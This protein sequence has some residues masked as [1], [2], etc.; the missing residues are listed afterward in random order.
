MSTLFWKAFKAS[1]VLLVAS[2]FVASGASAA[3]SNSHATA[4]DLSTA[5]MNLD[6]EPTA[7][8][9]PRLDDA[10]LTEPIPATDT[11]QSSVTVSPT[12]QLA[13]STF[14]EPVPAAGDTS[15][16]SNQEILQQIQRYGN[17]GST[18]LD[19]VTNVGQLRDVSPGDWAYEA[20]RSLVERY[21]CIAGYPDGTYR[22]NRALTRYEFAAGLNACLNQIERL[23]GTDGFDETEL[24]T[25][26]RL[27]QEFEAELA[28]LGARVDN[29]EGRVAFLEDNQFSTTTK[30]RGEVIFGLADTFGDTIDGGDDDTNTVFGDRVRLNFETSFT[31][32]DRLRTRLEAINMAEFNSGVTGTNM[33][34]LGFDGAD[35]NNVAI[36]ELWY[37]FP[38]GDNLIVQIDAANGEFQDTILDVVNPFFDSSGSGSIS[39]FGRFNP[40]YRTGGGAGG[41]LTY[42][43]GDALELSASYFAD[44]GDNPGEDSGLFNGTF[45][46]LGQITFKPTENITVAGTYVRS[47]Y[48]GADFD[49]E[50]NVL[51]DGTV[52]VT[53]STGSVFASQPF[54]DIATSADSFGIQANATFGRFSVGGWVGYQE[55][56]AEDDFG[57]NPLFPMLG[58]EF[59]VGEGDDAEV[60]NWAVNLALLDLGG[61]G[62][63]LGVVFGQP[64]KVTDN[65]AVDLVVDADGN[66]ILSERDD[67]DNSYH[68]EVFYRY[69][70]TD[71]IAITPGAFVIFNPEHNDDND[72]IWVGTIRT[73]FS[74]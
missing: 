54:G 23:I 39:R 13:D 3:E 56:E 68:L 69:Q 21:G 53:G 47:Y 59:L 30:L 70:L 6:T 28:T 33:T 34:R 15:V 22:G 24:E 35:G 65:D 10:A 25:L 8:I 50:G 38:F 46:A 66:Q 37:R 49:E 52:N 17:E 74:F 1:P 60:W 4:A 61:E 40:I 11:P 48:R 57:D 55:V 12:F 45:A 31:G 9:S 67:E 58:S 32:R 14:P 73:V 2:L 42:S 16:E 44:E 27:I 20:L 72:D 71:N 51:E 19:Q 63:K 41:T 64:P 36:D 18:S 7:S 43:L 5:A 26:R 62:N 29:L